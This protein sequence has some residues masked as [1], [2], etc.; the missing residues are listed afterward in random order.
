MIRRLT[1]AERIDWLS[2]S[3]KTSSCDYK[4]VQL[5]KLYLLRQT[6]ERNDDEKLENIAIAIKKSTD[7]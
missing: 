6:E 3:R 7:D 4:I 2:T 5:Q 1:K